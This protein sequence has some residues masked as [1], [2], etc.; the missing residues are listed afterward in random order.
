MFEY[1][2][3]LNPHIPFYHVNSPEFL[4]FGRIVTTLDTEQI[5]AAAKKIKNPA[6]GSAYLPSVDSFEALSIAKVVKNE[7]FGSLPAQMGYCWGH[8]TCYDA[9][10]WHKGCE[11]NIAV[12]P[13]VLILGHVWD[14]ED[15]K[16]D[17]AQFVA[18]YLP[19]GTAVE[20]FETT[21]HYCP[22]EVEETGFGC[23]VAL[24][25]GTNTELEIEPKNKM[26]FKKNKWILCH[27][28]SKSLIEKG[29]VAGLEGTMLE[30]KY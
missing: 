13:L 18:F 7:I 29:V 5:V 11:L 1:V 6:D 19:A 27:S 30:I 3:K 20:I 23:V 9:T 15:S 22:C 21:L 25:F 2:K 12:T 16:I 28:D 10:E 8:N 26:L 4:Q 17:S 24:P 14:V